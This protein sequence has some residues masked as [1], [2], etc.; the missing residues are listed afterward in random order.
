M[1]YKIIKSG[2]VWWSLTYKLNKFLEDKLVM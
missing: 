2:G 1:Y